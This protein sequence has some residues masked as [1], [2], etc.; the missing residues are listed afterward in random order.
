MSVKTYDEKNSRTELTYGKE[1]V[2]KIKDLFILIF[3]MRGLGV[4][5][6]KNLILCSPHE[7]YL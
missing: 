2:N 7:V 3:G 4:E 5:I 6:A 1:M